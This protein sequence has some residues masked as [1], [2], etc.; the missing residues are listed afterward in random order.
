MGLRGSCGSSRFMLIWWADVQMAALVEYMSKSLEIFLT[1]HTFSKIWNCM[2]GPKILGPFRKIVCRIPWVFLFWMVRLGLMGPFRKIVCQ[3]PWVFLFW[4]VRLGLSE[5]LGPLEVHTYF[6]LENKFFCAC[7]LIDFWV[8]GCP[9]NMQEENAPTNISINSV[10]R[11]R[12]WG[13]VRTQFWADVQMAAL[14]EY[15][16]LTL[17][18][19]LTWPDP[20]LKISPEA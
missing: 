16:W 10:F 19:D 6:F 11:E 9:N 3:I 15:T 5:S 20:D 7:R 14:V 18:G 8:S 13:K 1:S 4:M 17:F 2:H 12:C